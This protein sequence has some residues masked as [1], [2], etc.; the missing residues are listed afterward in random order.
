MLQLTEA[1]K[2]IVDTHCGTIH[3]PLQDVLFTVLTTPIKMLLFCPRCMTQH[4]DAPEP[5][6]GWTNPPH[7]IHK[8]GSCGLLWRPC[9]SYT[10]GVEALTV[11]MDEDEG[12]PGHANPAFYH[13]RSAA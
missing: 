9:D 4:I 7:R 5:A 2:E 3:K 8:C 10:T 13:N 12:N 6:T 11:G 1:Q